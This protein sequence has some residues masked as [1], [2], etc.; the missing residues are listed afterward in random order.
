MQEAME[1]MGGMDAI[2]GGGIASFATELNDLAD[3]ADKINLVFGRG[4]ATRLGRDKAAF[5]L[6]HA[7]VMV[8]NAHMGCALTR[9][10][11]QAQLK[12]AGKDAFVGTRSI[13][14]DP[15]NVTD[16]VESQITVNIYR[17]TD[18]INPYLAPVLNTW[19]VFPLVSSRS[20]MWGRAQVLPCMER[21]R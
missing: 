20:Q 1:E 18:P 12:G 4:A 14:I 3:V 11:W 7:W 10:E 8:K 16:I 15:K 21:K 19:C 2:I 17:C 13:T 5:D 9:E 6:E